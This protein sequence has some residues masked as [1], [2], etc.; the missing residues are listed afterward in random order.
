MTMKTPITNIASGQEKQIVR[1]GSNAIETALK[2]LEL[3]KDGVRRVI[4]HGGEF[5]LAIRNAAHTA[6]QNLSVFSDRFKDEEVASFHGYFSGYTK[7]VEITDQIDILRS[8]WPSLNPD[9]A[10]R[11]YREVY[12]TL[13]HPRWVEGP[14]AKI[15]QGFFSDKYGEELE[16]VLAAI[17]KDREGKFYNSCEGCLGEQYLRQTD[18]TLAKMRQLMKRQ[19]G[20]DILIVGCNF[21]VRY[22]QPNGTHIISSVRRARE[23]FVAGEFGCSA[24]D[25]GTMILT[26]RVRLK[27]CNDLGIDCTGDEY[28]PAADGDFSGALGFYF[29]D[30]EVGFG[31][32]WVDHPSG[33]YGSVSGCLPQSVES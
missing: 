26:N 9:A 8:H 15:R 14:F 25:G 20:S 22:P 11:Y 13:Q 5:V 24:K 33:H 4:E 10:L 27:H 19:P 30:G 1:F 7:P 2:T 6:L 32:C 3:D 16:E 18:H 12:S 28:A 31:S 29:S 21:G 23:K 17:K